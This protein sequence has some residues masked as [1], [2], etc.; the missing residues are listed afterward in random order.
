M[1]PDA[2]SGDSSY[3]VFSR[4]QWASFGSP[5]Q[6]TLPVADISRLVATSEPL[7]ADEVADIYHPLAQFLEMQATSKGDVNTRV[8]TFLALDRQPVPYIIGI[9]G[10]VA[11]GKSTT[12]R[13]LQ[14]LLR[15]TASSPRVD[16]LT[17]D[18]FLY[19]NATLEERGLMDRKGFPESYDQRGLVALLAATKAGAPEVVAPIYSHHAYDIVP[20]QFQV[21]RRPDILL[22]EGLNV[23]QVNTKGA[24][25]DHVVVSDFFDFSIYVDAAETDVAQ[26]FEDR[27]LD[28]RATVLQ[29]PDSFF[30][31]FASLPDD[32]VRAIAHTIWSDIN[33]IN[34]HENVAPTRGRATL[35]LEKDHAHRVHRVLFRRS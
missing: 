14:A 25:P 31:R 17:T 13:V 28:L 22:V 1:V 16:L 9:A 6:S 21:I 3:D 18:G 26:W 7:L 11:V 24:S 4:Q 30:H 10:G 32:E 33:L 23:L 34:L 8:D 15:Q 5:A 12:A 19:P 29:E 27:L 20:G 2:P 35:I